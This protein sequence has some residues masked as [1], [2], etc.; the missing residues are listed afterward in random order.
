MPEKRQVLLVSPHFPPVNAADH[1][2]I[3]MAIPHLGEFGW[4]PTVLTVRESAVVGTRD[5]LLLESL[6]ED[7]V[8]EACGALPRRTFG[9]GGMGSLGLRCLWPMALAGDRLL[10]DGAFDLVYFSTTQFPVMRLGP[11]WLRRF[12]VPYVLDYQDPWVSDYYR[13]NGVR[14]P[15]GPLRFALANL[16]GRVSEPACVRGAA[17][18]TSVSESYP[19]QLHERYP[20]LPAER[21]HVLTFGAAE[22]DFEVLEKHAV[23]QA[24]F[25]PHDGHTHWVYVGRG[26]ADMRVALS[27]L[28]W[29]LRRWREVDPAAANRIRLHF[30]G[31]SYAGGA[32]AEKTVEPLA[33][34]FGVG[35][36]VEERPER[37]AYF[38]ALR[39]LRDADAL[40]VP[41]SND[42]GYTA[43]KLYPYIL[44]RRPLLAIFHEA[45]SVLPILEATRAGQGISFSERDTAESIG[46]RILTNW[47]EDGCFA[48]T[49]DVDW[50]TFAPYTARERTRELCR[51]FDRAAAPAGTSAAA[52]G[53]TQATDGAPR[54]PQKLVHR[55]LRRP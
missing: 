27:G 19:Q 28:F 4:T 21:C 44:A 31:T 26:G 34:E 14:P 9:G 42:P 17:A 49:P 54:P 29:A 24:F 41:G 30:L 16:V 20:D 46:R 3:R 15:G 50:A 32:G 12:R 55:A 1:Q 52:A 18:I 40:V 51:I 2:R 7:L 53:S 38:E 11:R 25:D 5:P 45:S 22:R 39:C 36:M 47:I 13:L 23:R 37:M 43:S 48:R 35:D 10:R 8:I 6:P 33:V